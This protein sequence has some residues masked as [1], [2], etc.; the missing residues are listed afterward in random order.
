MK[1]EVFMDQ[2]YE[3]STTPFLKKNRLFLRGN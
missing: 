3:A 1:A 2:E